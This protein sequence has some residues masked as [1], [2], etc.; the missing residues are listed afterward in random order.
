MQGDLD[1]LTVFAVAEGE[2]VSWAAVDLDD[3]P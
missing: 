3:W 2:A 1:G